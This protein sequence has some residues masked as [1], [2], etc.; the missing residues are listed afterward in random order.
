MRYGFT[1][2][3]GTLGRAD[4]DAVTIVRSEYDRIEA[5]QRDHGR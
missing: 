4:E 1:M 3:I 5:E 2:P